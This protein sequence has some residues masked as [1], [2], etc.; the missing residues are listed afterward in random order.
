MSKITGK[1]E[2]I[3]SADGHY[4]VTWRFDFSGDKP[5]R[6]GMWSMPAVLQSDMAA[7]VNKEGL[8]RASIQVKNC[9]TREVTTLAE[10]DGW[11]FCNFEWIAQGR[12]PGGPGFGSK[13]LQSQVV[14]LRLRARD[15][16]YEVFTN[17]HVLKRVRREDDKKFHYAGYGK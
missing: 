10:V 1:T 15:S 5:S 16:L 8:I 4:L 13:Q 7:Y 11:D 12:L 6:V 9:A 2:T 3:R 14:G 17:G